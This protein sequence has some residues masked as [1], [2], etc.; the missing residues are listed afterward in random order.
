MSTWWVGGGTVPPTSIGSTADRATA[1]FE[2]LIAGVTIS[3]VSL[4][5]QKNFMN[6]FAFLDGQNVHLA[7]KELG[8]QIDWGKFRIYLKEKYHVQRAYIFLGYVS[9]NEGLYNFLRNYGYI[10]VFK[11]T[12]T[13]G[14]ITKG[15][16]D[17]NIALQV[18]LD[19]K[20]FDQAILI[21]NDGDFYCL[22]DYLKARNKLHSVISPNIH[23]C[24]RLL[25]QSAQEKMQTIT[26][27]QKILSKK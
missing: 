25:K 9:R 3:M 19:Y 6:N 22:V 21:T 11:P 7:V 10:L 2:A 18:M 17:L 15:N 1:D 24:A 12:I 23:K 16:V 8:W 26:F 5:P 13:K 4:D 20:A 27:S 14:S